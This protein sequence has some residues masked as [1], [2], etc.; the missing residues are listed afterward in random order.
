MAKV[1]AKKARAA[2]VNGKPRKLTIPGIP[3]G[4]TLDG[5]PILGFR[6]PRGLLETF[7]AKHGRTRGVELLREF[8]A[9]SVR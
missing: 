6:V 9:R 7:D 8:M 1:K 4:L 2:T 3:E 5:N